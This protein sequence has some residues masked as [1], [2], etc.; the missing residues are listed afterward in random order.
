MHELTHGQRNWVFLR[1]LIER[2]NT[3]TPLDL[4]VIDYLTLINDPDARDQ[5]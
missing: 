3:A 4:V 1:S 2:E 5:V